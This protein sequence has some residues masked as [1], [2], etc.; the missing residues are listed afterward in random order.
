MHVSIARIEDGNPGRIKR[1]ERAKLDLD[2][3]FGNSLE[4]RMVMMVMYIG[5]RTTTLAFG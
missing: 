3:Y 4:L 5:E 2:L 1:S